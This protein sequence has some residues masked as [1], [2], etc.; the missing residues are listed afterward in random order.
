[1]GTI[2]KS[3]KVCVKT[4][5]CFAFLVVVACLGKGV[6]AAELMD[7]PLN[8]PLTWDE[9][10]SI[11]TVE[12]QV[13]G[14]KIN[15]IVDTGSSN[16]VIT[17]STAR[18]LNID[19]AKLPV[20][21]TGKDHAGNPVPIK[22]LPA[23]QVSVAGHDTN[24]KTVV[25]IPD[26]PDLAK[27]G[28]AGMISPQLMFDNPARLDFRQR[29]WLIN[30]VATPFFIDKPGKAYWYKKNKIFT[31]IAVQ[32]KDTVW[33]MLDSGAGSSKFE[34]A[35]LGRE[36]T[37]A[38]CA[39]QGVAGCGKGQKDDTPVTL[40]FGGAEIK[41][42]QVVLQKKIQHGDKPDEKALIGMSILRF[43]S[44]TI[45]QRLDQEIGIACTTR[46]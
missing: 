30:P 38:D 12:L 46:Q 26:N 29:Q 16:Q 39:I 23:L 7:K 14:Q 36:L 34:A 41:L 25:I 1:M 33:G 27:L 24:L 18:L 11:F 13:A 19:T 40:A 22:M 6:V 21:G 44:I 32:G 17:E 35:Y 37:E 43:C 15:M 42:P 4:I 8:I 9:R 28:M 20:V 2:M 5:R 31:E 3:F 45:N 10:A